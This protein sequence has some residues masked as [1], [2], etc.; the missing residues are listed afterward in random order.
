MAR[1]LVPASAQLP[2][3]LAAEIAGARDTL[4]AA[5]AASTQKAYASD[6]RR[7]CDF[8]EACNVEA[9]PA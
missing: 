5:K 3:D 9:L 7:F 1:D 2:A 8:C 4:A 6:W